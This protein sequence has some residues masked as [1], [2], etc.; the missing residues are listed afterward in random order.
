[1]TTTT[2]I[3]PKYEVFEQLVKT[4]NKTLNKVANELGIGVT[5]FYEWR[6]GISAPKT[7]KMILISEYFGINIREFFEGE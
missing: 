3:K 6:D 4:S 7:Y 1:V 2:D 5:T